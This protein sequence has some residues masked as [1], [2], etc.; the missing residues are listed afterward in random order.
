MKALLLCHVLPAKKDGAS[1]HTKAT[2]QAMGVCN[3]GPS[4]AFCLRKMKMLNLH[5]AQHGA[6]WSSG[7]E[8]ERVTRMAGKDS[9]AELRILLSDASPREHLLQTTNHRGNY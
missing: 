3:Q 5:N 2:G 6:L 4:T 9:E 1:T 7:R 8:V